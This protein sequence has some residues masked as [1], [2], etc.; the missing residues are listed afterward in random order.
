M[1][2]KEARIARLH[3]LELCFVT[4]SGSTKQ[5]SEGLKEQL[6]L[7]SVVN[8]SAARTAAGR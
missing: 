4:L 3:D 7:R 6:I 5:Q 8:I 2:E 1:A